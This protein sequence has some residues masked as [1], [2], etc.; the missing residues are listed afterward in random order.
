MPSGPRRPRPFRFR[1]AD[2]S[3][4]SRSLPRIAACLPNGRRFRIAPA[5]IA[6]RTSGREVDRIALAV[7][8]H[9]KRGD[10]VVASIHW[11]GNWGY[12]V[13]RAMRDFAHGLIDAA[14]VDV[15]HGHSSH[16]PMGI[17]VH[18][19]RPIFYGCGDFINDYEGISGYQEFQ[20][21]LR[22]MYFVTL[23]TETCRLR[24]LEVVPMRVRRFRIE[25]APRAGARW[26]AGTIE[27]ESRRLGTRLAA[28]A[29][30]RVVL[31]PKESV[32]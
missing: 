14:Q 16:H 29:D 23:E 18:G 11:G 13:P 30:G 1:A 15:V 20:P 32:S 26:L 12:A 6:S 5:W 27:R 19:D 9:R 10:L 25:H 4:C 21:E 2:G 24:G 31:G 3:S 7:A 28:R 8:R 22:A 17:E